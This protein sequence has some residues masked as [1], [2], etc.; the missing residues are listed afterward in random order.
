MLYQVHQPIF[1]LKLLITFQ[2]ASPLS[3]FEFSIARVTTLSSLFAIYN[4]PFVKF[5]RHYLMLLRMYFLHS[6]INGFQ[7]DFYRYFAV[8]T[9][10]VLWCWVN[11]FLWIQ[12]IVPRYLFWNMC[13]PFSHVHNQK[14]WLTNRAGDRAV[15]DASAILFQFTFSIF[16]Q[17]DSRTFFHSA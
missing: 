1:Y 5:W 11:Q 16:K 9:R 10:K 12:I 7:T 14:F 3:I 6:K 2:L 8:W 13:K 17:K 15:P 4:H